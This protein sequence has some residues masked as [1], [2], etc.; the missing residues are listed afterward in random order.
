LENEFINAT[1]ITIA[2]SMVTLVEI[3]TRKTEVILV[4]HGE[5]DDS[6]LL[7]VQDIDVL[8]VNYGTGD[9]QLL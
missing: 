9:E 7:S 6:L 5:Y 2:F 4:V 8:K 1:S 3:R